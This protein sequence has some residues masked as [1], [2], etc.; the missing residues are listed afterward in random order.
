MVIKVKTPSKEQKKV[1]EQRGKIVL[2]ACPGSG[3]TFTVAHILAKRLNNWKPKH[4]GIAAITFTNVACDE[5]KE[6]LEKMNIGDVIGYP[7]YLG[8]IDSFINKY[9]FLP[10]G[11]LVINCQNRPNIVGFEQ[12]VWNPSGFKWFWYKSK[13]EKYSHCYKNMC[14][15]IDFSYSIDGKVVNIKDDDKINCPYNRT[16]CT[17]LKKQ[18]TTEGYANQADAN[19]FAMCTLE[20]YPEI[21]KILSRRF[22]EFIVD[23]AQDTS[24]TQMKIMDLLVDKGLSEIM[25]IGDQDQAIYE[26]RD[27]KPQ[28]F[29]NK[30]DDSSWETMTLNENLRSSQ[31][32]CEA[33]KGFSSL[34]N[35]SKATGETAKLNI[36]PQIVKYRGDKLR[37]LK[38]YFISECRKYSIEI[39]PEKVA[40]LIRGHALLNR[41]MGIEKDTKP[42]RENNTLTKRL[43]EAV[44]FRDCTP[45]ELKKSMKY[46]ESA[47]SIVCFGN[48]SYRKVELVEK[49][50]EKVGIRIWQI[51]LW[52]LLKSLPKSNLS[53]EKWIIE[54]RKI[55][56]IK[57]FKDKKWQI[58]SEDIFD[59]GVKRR[60]K[61]NKWALSRPVESFFKK[62][63]IIDNVYMGTIHS[64]KGKTYEA[65]LVVI[66]EHHAAKGNIKELAT[67]S[68][69][70]EEIR[71][72][73][74][75]MTR[76][77][78][79][80][81]I[82]VP[83]NTEKENL[84]RFPDW[85]K[86][87]IITLGN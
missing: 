39:A 44:Y 11:H 42:W 66:P 1:I 15:L 6:Q 27:A 23:E 8:T 10:F 50:D 38:E 87:N 45:L 29:I 12:N 34:P 7:H 51:G 41:M 17:E 74:V 35:I 58:S 26:W 70:H 47:C 20:R 4:F 60:G 19:Y 32:I 68:D 13:K 77:R 59:L 54:T 78:K 83:D 81:I 3:K 36:P 64:A 84:H 31:L 46:I 33:T 48:N 28:I 62:A 56:N 53:L 80:L 5:I 16:R 67:V 61:D 72:V 71:T 25:L 2:R 57:W 22:P 73:Y 63:S 79:L 75:A 18:F 9:I 49:V 37:I 76:P 65:I 55:F 24:E 30:I 69:G 86:N 14:K 43:A 82:A 85:M 40:I 52:R 21:A